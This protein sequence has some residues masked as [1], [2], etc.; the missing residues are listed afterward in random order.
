MTNNSKNKRKNI[1]LSESF[2]P[3]PIK[4]GYGYRID[5]KFAIMVRT[6]LV[7]MQNFKLLPVLLLELCHKNFLSRRERVIVIRYLPPVIQ[8]NLK[9]HFLCLKTTKLYPPP[10]ISMVFKQNKNSYAQ[11]LRRLISKTTAATPW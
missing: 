3:G 9:N 11:F 10:H 6:I 4:Q 5:L 1:C 8:Q 2:W 7:N